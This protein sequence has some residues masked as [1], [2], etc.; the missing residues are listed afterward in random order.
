MVTNRPAEKCDVNLDFALTDGTSF[1][2]PKNG[3]TDKNNVLTGVQKNVPLTGFSS[4]TKLFCGLA[5]IP[6]RQNEQLAKKEGKKA[7]NAKIQVL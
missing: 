7:F 3:D 4:F 1:T 5:R 2:T 6:S